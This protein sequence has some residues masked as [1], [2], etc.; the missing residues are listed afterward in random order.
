[1]VLL[2]VSGAD[3]NK[4]DQDGY[5]P[6]IRA[7]NNDNLNLV[8]FLVGKGAKINVVKQKTHLLFLASFL[9]NLDIFEFLIKQPEVVKIENEFGA[10]PLAW[11]AKKGDL[12]VLKLLIENG[13]DVNHQDKNDYTA[14]HMAIMDQHE[15]TALFLLKN[16]ANP[17]LVDVKEQFPIHLSTLLGNFDITK[18]LLQYGSK[19]DESDIEGMTPLMNVIISGNVRLIKAYIKYLIKKN[20][21]K[22]FIKISIYKK[23]SILQW[24]L[25]KHPRAVIKK[26][27]HPYDLDSFD[28]I[29]KYILN[30]CGEHL[31]FFHRDSYGCTIAHWLAKVGAYK[32]FHFFY[33]ENYKNINYI[34]RL[35]TEKSEG[36]DKMSALEFVDQVLSEKYLKI[37]EEFKNDLKLT[38]DV[39]N[40]WLDFYSRSKELD[41]IQKR[42]MP[43]N[44]DFHYHPK[45]R[46]KG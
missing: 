30:Y 16:G 44:S 3:V 32:S 46:K 43:L 4:V 15:K 23:R 37:D 29:F 7:I 5:T 24:L 1:M 18:K 9:K 38:K 42:Q 26:N 36:K 20:K 22:A 14:L 19:P 33:K 28:E 10:Q 34:N 35:L 6:L 31:D 45:K 21:T 25:R 8:T 41:K 11:F 17:N 12:D 40:D 2:V 27:E 13:A 39:I